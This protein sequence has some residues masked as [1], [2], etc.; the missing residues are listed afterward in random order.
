MGDAAHF[1]SAHFNDARKRKPT[2]AALAKQP[3]E[4]KLTWGDPT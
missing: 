1:G 4:K 3:G 2:Q